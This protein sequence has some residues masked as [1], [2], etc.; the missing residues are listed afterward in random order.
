MK[1]II[2]YLFIFL[3]CICT[4]F[5]NTLIYSNAENI[6]ES[7]MEDATLTH[8]ETEQSN[9][10]TIDSISVESIDNS[11]QSILQ[12]DE[13]QP[14]PQEIINYN[15]GGNTSV[16]TASILPKASVNTNINANAIG[17]G[18]IN[19]EN[20]N[21][22][23]GPST[24]SSKVG[25]LKNGDYVEIYGRSNNWYK[26]IYN[27]QFAYVSCSYVTLN[28]LERGID[29]SKWNGDI[30][31]NKVK[32]SGIDYVIIRAGY[33]TSTVDP[34]FKSY[35]EGAS[36]A[37][38]KVGIY[39]FSY[40]TSPEK[41]KIEAEKCLQ[42]I[43]PYRNKI[44]YPVYYDFEYASVDYAQ[45]QGVTVTKSLAT[46]MA[47]VFINTVK[48]SGYDTGIY[49]NKNFS[50]NYF[51]SNLL[52]SNNFW[53]AQYSSVCTIN[54]PYMMWQYSEKGT[55]DGINGYVDMNYTCLKSNKYDYN[56][57]ILPPNND[58]IEVDSENS[59]SYKTHVE[60]Y[61]WQNWKSNG[62]I[63]GTIGKN[64]QLEA[65]NIKLNNVPSNANV[66]YQTHIQDYGWQNWKSNGDISGTVGKN[67]QLEAIRIK[68]ENMDGYSIKYRVHIEDYGW[69]NWTY[70]GQTA[71]TVGQNKQLEA[72]EIKI[73]KSSNMNIE[74]RSHIED[75]GW[76]NWKS[77][78]QPSG[79]VGQN[80]QLEAIEIKLI[81][82]PS[83]ANIIY[84]AH[85][86]DYGWQDWKSN[87]ILSGT[88]GQ[89]KQLEAIKI[90]LENL[91]GYRVKYRVHVEDYGWQNWKSDGELAGTVGQNKQIEAIEIKL[92]KK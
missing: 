85:I 66:I 45:K 91:N 84:Q 58:H 19:T 54:K 83:N 27:N 21:V 38:L 57:S 32:A 10:S 3:L 34:N 2:N 50:D 63:S 56:G 4:V 76:Q 70:N 8:L 13:Y 53:V 46:E 74:Y 77:S 24:S 75:Y 78:S 30:N 9:D 51:E 41:A 23:S 18:N 44:T 69:S 62:D 20:L 61:G 25:L 60:D 64:K 33:G 11:K 86:Q 26:I 29:V 37:G 82:A 92:E 6:Q 5:Q 43:N 1:K 68:L 14:D 71:G 28:I 55:V 80:K 65:I 88:F 15:M 16:S 42:T 87:G 89:N 39:W 90:K 47:N 48:S 12:E 59:V 81:D 79:T 72:I 52:Y 49:S 7:T 31:W 73:V 67:K 17:S 36:A 40:A 22:R 35:I